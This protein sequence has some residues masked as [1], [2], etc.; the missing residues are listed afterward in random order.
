LVG[1]SLKDFQRKVTQV[2]KSVGFSFNDFD[3]IVH[4]LQDTG[5]ER[6]ITIGVAE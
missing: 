2:M 5:V 1:E 3:F 6:V 4:S